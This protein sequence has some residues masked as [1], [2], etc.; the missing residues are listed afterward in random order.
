MRRVWSQPGSQDK[1]E[2]HKKWR[3][4]LNEKP[5]QFIRL[6]ARLE[7]EHLAKVAQQRKA[8]RAQPPAEAEEA[9]DGTE[10]A[11]ELIELWFQER[12]A[13]Q[14]EENVVLAA[15]PCSSGNSAR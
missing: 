11:L 10:G 1:R 9:D 13:K 15:L 12:T 4:L 6:M 14:A 5:W 8:A 2:A 7:Q 3:Q